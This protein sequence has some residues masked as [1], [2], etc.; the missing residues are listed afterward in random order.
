VESEEIRLR[1]RI[2]SIGFWPA[3]TKDTLLPKLGGA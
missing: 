1:A 2:N 3:S